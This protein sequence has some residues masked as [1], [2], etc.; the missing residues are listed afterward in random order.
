MSTTQIWLIHSIELIAAIAGL[1]YI[2]KYRDD[3]LSRYFV[4]FLWFTV[5]IEKIG[6]IRRFIHK[7]D[8]LIHLKGTFLGESNYWLY[9]PYLIISVVFYI[10]Y[11]SLNIQSGKFRFTLNLLSILY[12][13]SSIISFLIVDD[14]FLG[15][16]SAYGFIVGSVL[17]LLSVSL[18]FYEVLQSDII[19]NF[20][21]YFPFY[22]AI[23]VLVFH[24]SVTPLFIYSKYYSASKNPEFVKVYTNILMIANIFMYTCYT[25][26]FV[27]CFRKNKSYY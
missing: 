18:Y 22:V 27:I 11:L 4:L 26:G 9:N 5:I 24:L 12:F 14:L 3:K 25:I 15:S 16:Y 6:L 7:V 1:F 21:K 10:R 17:I 23:G 2:K 19:L 20:S 13:V 8:S